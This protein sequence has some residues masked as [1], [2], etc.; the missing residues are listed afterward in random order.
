MLVQGFA[1]LTLPE[2]YK[3]DAVHNVELF[4]D[5]GHAGSSKLANRRK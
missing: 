4:K 5:T 3:D 2:R 1:F